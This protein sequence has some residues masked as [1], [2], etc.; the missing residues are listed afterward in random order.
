MS[1]LFCVKFCVLQRFEA[2]HLRPTFTKVMVG[3]QG[4]GGLTFYKFNWELKKTPSFLQE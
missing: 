3:K 2:I 1:A 4:F